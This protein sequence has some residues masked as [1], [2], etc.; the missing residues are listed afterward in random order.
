ML[1]RHRRHNKGGHHYHVKL[2]IFNIYRPPLC[3]YYALRI[4]AYVTVKKRYIAL[5]YLLIVIIIL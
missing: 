5:T 3:I 4:H 1:A 2:F